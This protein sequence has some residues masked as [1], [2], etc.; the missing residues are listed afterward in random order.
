LYLFRYYI[1]IML[2]VITATNDRPLAFSF[3]EKWIRHQTV[4]PDEWIVV[5]DT[6]RTNTYQYTMGQTVINRYTKR[7]CSFTGNYEIAFT[8]AKGDKIIICEDDDFYHPSYIETISKLLDKADMAGLINDI[9]YKV[10]KR[11]FQRMLNNTHASLAATAFNR[12]VLPFAGNLLKQYGPRLDMWL[13]DE[14]V[15]KKVLVDNKAKDGKPLHVG[16][17]QLPGKAGA[18]AGHTNYGSSDACWCVL[19]HWIG[20]ENTKVYSGIPKEAWD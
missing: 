16:M 1:N 13:W 5:N 7:K 2:S 20:V 9:Y 11:A 10:R 8:K 14:F 3:L 19:R 4:Q 18:G 12:N 17:K 15:G 6:G